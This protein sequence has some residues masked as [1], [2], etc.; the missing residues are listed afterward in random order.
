MGDLDSGSVS[1]KRQHCLL[2]YPHILAQCRI[3]IAVYVNSC[4]TY[5]Q[6]DECE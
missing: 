6:F 2:T 4:S 1:A 3:Y 5:M